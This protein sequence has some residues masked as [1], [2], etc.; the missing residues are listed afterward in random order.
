[1]WSLPQ[2]CCNT[3]RIVQQAARPRCRSGCH[4]SP[5]RCSSRHQQAPAGRQ[6]PVVQ[7]ARQEHHLQRL[8]LLC[9]AAGV[10]L[11][12]VAASEFQPT[13]FSKESYYVTLGLFLLSL[14]G[15]HL[16]NMRTGSHLVPM[17]RIEPGCHCVQPPQRHCTAFML[18]GRSVACTPLDMLHSL[19][20]GTSKAT[21]VG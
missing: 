9:L 10:E 16:S 20:F 13:G 8:A 21:L 14:P 5:V 1:M 3:P 15:K 7:E 2:N 12:A 4:V 11:P 17:H 18:A 6:T 19:Y